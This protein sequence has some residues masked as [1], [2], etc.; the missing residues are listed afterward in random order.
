MPPPPPPYATTR[1]MDKGIIL[2][3]NGF[4]ECTFFPCILPQKITTIDN[5][6]HNLH[7]HSL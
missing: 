2:A 6:P 3:R 7:Q 1:Y 5:N 4:L